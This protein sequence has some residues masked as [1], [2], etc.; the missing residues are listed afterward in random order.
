ME[1]LKLTVAEMRVESF[2]LGETAGDR[3]TVEA[4]AISA[5]GACCTRRDTGCS[6]V[7]TIFTG[8]CC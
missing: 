2:V 3:G 6:D 7:T 8:N 1:K 5:G 4:R